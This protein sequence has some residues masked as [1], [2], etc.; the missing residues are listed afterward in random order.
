MATVL[1]SSFVEYLFCLLSYIITDSVA[2]AAAAVQA[3]APSSDFVDPHF[4][5]DGAGDQPMDEAESEQIQ[6]LF[7]KNRNI[8]ACNKCSFTTVRKGWISRYQP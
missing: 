5:D 8:Y 3:S 2:P 7:D 4:F 1:T 6:T